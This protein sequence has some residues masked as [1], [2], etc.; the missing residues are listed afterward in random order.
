MEIGAADCGQTAKGRST[1]ASCAGH[2][3]IFEQFEAEALRD[4][5]VRVVAVSR[6]AWRPLFAGL[7]LERDRRAY[8]PDIQP[9]RRPVARSTED[10]RQ[11]VRGR[12]GDG[13]QFALMPKALTVCLLSPAATRRRC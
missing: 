10:E 1:C 4:G 11:R 8:A 2:S 6:E 3:G 9:R 7:V 5:V 12:A 13:N